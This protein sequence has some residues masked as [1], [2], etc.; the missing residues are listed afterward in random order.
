[1]STLF[2]K[3]AILPLI[4]MTATA[5][6]WANV[7]ISLN[8]YVS[9]PGFEITNSPLG[10]CGTAYGNHPLLCN[11][12]V[13]DWNISNGSGA[14][15]NA[16]TVQLSG[17]PLN[18][19]GDTQ[20]NPLQGNNAAYINNLVTYSYNSPTPYATQWEAISQ[21]LSNMTLQANTTYSLTYDV[22]RRADDVGGNFRIQV[23]AVNGPAIVGTDYWIL[24]GDTTF[25]ASGKWYSETLTFTTGNAG[26]FNATPTIYLVNDGSDAPYDGSNFSVAQIEFDTPEPALFVPLALM[27]G[28]V[29]FAFRSRSRAS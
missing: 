3:A 10:D 1:M 15:G 2:L 22:A 16:G 13:A 12:S 4:V 18:V 17:Q 14:V 23:N 29:G 21:T 20:L 7:D 24:A 6:A 28:L 19:V 26:T 11:G 27:L 5:P 25:F 8:Q 9:N